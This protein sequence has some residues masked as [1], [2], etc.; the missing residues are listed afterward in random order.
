MTTKPNP[1]SLVRAQHRAIQWVPLLG[2]VAAGLTLTLGALWLAHPS[3]APVTNWQWLGLGWLAGLAVTGVGAV[4]LWRA[5]RRSLLRSAAEMDAALATHNRLET[6][7]ALH[8]AQDAMAKAQ[9][10]ETEQFLQ[11]SHISPRRRW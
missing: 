11:Q 5:R 2:L 3:P 7:T 9:R 6:A 10:A 4:A 1:E 8:D